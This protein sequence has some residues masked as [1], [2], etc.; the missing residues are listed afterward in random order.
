MGWYPSSVMWQR[1]GGLS[2][3]PCGEIIL[4][5]VVV[6]QTIYSTVY[7]VVLLAEGTAACASCLGNML[8]LAHFGAL[9]F[10]KS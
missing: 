7:I 6:E 1:A 3:R 5:V 10:V 2:D 9:A 4:V 8:T